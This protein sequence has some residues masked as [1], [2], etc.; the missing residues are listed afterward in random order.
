MGVEHSGLAGIRA[1]LQCR[2]GMSTQ[3]VERDNGVE[4]VIE[5]NGRRVEDSMSWA[6]YAVIGSAGVEALAI[7]LM[8]NMRA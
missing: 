3:I 5:C 1:R 7:D 8:T 2:A 4:I 6:D